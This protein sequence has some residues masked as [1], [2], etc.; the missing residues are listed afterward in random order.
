[1]KALITGIAGQSGSYLSRLLLDNGYEVYGITKHRTPLDNLRKLEI[2]KDVMITQGNICDP[3]FVSDCIA[4]V[5]PDEIYNLA[6]MSHVGHSFKIPAETCAVNYTGYL[7][8]LLAARR[9]CPKAR[10]YQAGTS[11]MFGYAAQEKQDEET[12]FKPMSPYAI[13]KVAS[14]WAGVNARH[15]ADQFVCNGILF[16]HESPLRQEDFV[17]RKITK[18]VARI[19]KGEDYILRLGNIYSRRD[20]GHAKDYVEGMWLMLSGGKPD[21]F[22]LSTGETHTVKEFVRLAFEAAGMEITFLGDGVEEIGICCERRVMEIDP[23]FYRP[24]DLTYLCGDASKAKAVLGWRPTI[25][26]EQL[27][28]EMVRSDLS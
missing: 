28:N 20:W 5:Q 12:P 18:A 11:E 4:N 9:Q 15:E 2:D 14:Y 26:F 16:N 23:Q 10:I 21:D 17:T 27:V 13:S 25:G 24:N 1:M 19:A 6:A 7:N 22:V 3:S 8:V